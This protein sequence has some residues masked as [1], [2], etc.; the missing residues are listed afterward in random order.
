[1]ERYTATDA[2]Q[3]GKSQIPNPKSAFTLIELLVVIAI[4]GIL[5]G[6]LLTAVQAAREAARRLQCGNNLKQ[7]ALAVQSYDQAFSTLP[8]GCRSSPKNPYEF[9][10]EGW[11]TN[12]YCWPHFLANYLEQ[13]AWSAG[14]DFTTGLYTPINLRMRK[15]R[16]PVFS[17]PSAG[18]PVMV[19]EPV[20]DDNHTLFARWRGNYVANWGN[21][22]NAQ[23]DQPGPPAVPFGG[24]PFTYGQTRQF[25]HFQDGTS[26]TLL[27]SETL[28][29]S[30]TDYQGPLG[31]IMNGE[32]GQAFD[33]WL[34]PNSSAPDVVDRMCPY[35]P[36]DGGTN[37]QVDGD[38]NV[39]IN[40][41]GRDALLPLDQHN[42]ARSA[43]LG[44]VNAALG[45]GSVRFTSDF[46]DLTTWRALSTTKGGEAIADDKF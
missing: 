19:H 3:I 14:F 15:V 22:G 42:A 46:I 1:M 16:V 9:I 11:W 44:G 35:K 29:P 4:I 6:L 12:D 31:C 33:T 25:A 20:S 28:H 38:G 34:T 39:N 13:T 18:A 7:L 10:P 23:R 17:C 2:L 36:G 45:D 37:C 5:M 30:G 40:Y 43:H 41:K 21:T 27:L 32:G 24:A 26:N 8:F